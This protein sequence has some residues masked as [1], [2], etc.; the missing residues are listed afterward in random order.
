MMGKTGKSIESCPAG[1][2]VG[3]LGIDKHIVKSCTLADEL[4]VDACPFVKMSFSVSPVVRVGLKA[5]NPSDQPELIEGLK[6]LVKSDPLVLW[7]MDEE[8]NIVVAGAGEL[9]LEII[10]KDLRDDYCN[11]I[12]I[13]TSLPAVTFMETIVETSPQCLAK[14]ANKLNRV[15]ASCSP[16]SDDLVKAIEDK[17]LVLDD[18]KKLLDFGWESDQIKKIWARHGTNFLVDCTKGVDY[19]LDIKDHI[20]QAFNEVV[21]SGVLA[22]EKMRGI[23]F[24]LHDFMIHADHA[25]RGAR[26]FTP[27]AKRCFYACQLTGS[28]RLVEPVFK[29]DIATNEDC[30][31]ACYSVVNRRRGVVIGVETKE[32]TPLRV[33]SSYIPV[34]ESFGLTEMLRSQTSGKA[35]PQCVFDHWDLIEGDPLVEGSKTGLKVIEIRKRKEMNEIEIPPLS[36]FLDKL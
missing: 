23:V 24:N 33:M 6:K 1:N 22:G 31:G 35:L 18:Y 13:L 19:L 21:V 8:N 7:E 11:G 3:I 4:E 34:V 25:H 14:S 20:V 17:S 27:A 16:L 2:V 32:G 12:K 10:L 15:T 36:R 5:A 28:P 26:Q 30:I 29:V 9:H